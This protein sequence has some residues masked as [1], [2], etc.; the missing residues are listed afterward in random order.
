MNYIIITG[1][2]RGLG[3]A[4]AKELMLKDNYLFCISRKQNDDLIKLADTNDIKMDYFEFDLTQLTQIEGLMK[5]IANKIK[6]PAASITLINN[7]GTVS[8]IK[9]IEKCQSLEIVDNLSLN[10]MAPM[11]LT[12]EFIKYFGDWETEKKIINISSG[13]GKNVYYGWSC[14]SSAKSGL[15]MFTRSVA[16]EQ[17]NKK[18]PVKILSIAPGVIDTDMQKEIRSTDPENF[19]NVKRFIE[20]KEKGQLLSPDYAA[21]KIIQLIFNGNW[22]N[23]EVLD[24]RDYI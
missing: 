6:N 3:D 16:L 20:L 23:G 24:I 8:P 1:A 22:E 15:N 5:E 14:Y 10:L 11:I 18:N 19:I 13:A 21:E 4:F 7:A 17:E 12:S 2:S 9:T